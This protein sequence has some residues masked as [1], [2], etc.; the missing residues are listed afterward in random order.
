MGGLSINDVHNLVYFI[1]A[2]QQASFPSPNEFNS[3]ANLANIE[4]F[5]YYNDERSK[6]LIKVKTGESL[7]VPPILSNF[8]VYQ[9]PVTPS[10]GVIQQPDGYLYD[11]ELISAPSVGLQTYIKKVDYDKVTNYINSSFDNPTNLNPIF[12]ELADT[13]VIYPNSLNNI[14]LT[15]LK[16]PNNV[17]WAYTLVNNRPVYDPVNSIDF[18]FSGTELNRI[19]AR[20]L[21]YMSISIRD[22]ELEQYAAEMVQGAS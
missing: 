7:Y 12:V 11:L 14:R 8:V 22:N 1:A 17:L 21:K 3:Y 20:V 16:Q 18:E 9:M 10:L 5:N 13:L 15:Y 4:L 19:V 6:M 2:K